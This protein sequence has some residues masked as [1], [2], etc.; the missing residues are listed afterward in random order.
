MVFVHCHRKMEVQCQWHAS[1][2][3][4]TYLPIG[5]FNGKLDFSEG[6]KEEEGVVE[7]ESKVRTTPDTT[8]D[9][10]TTG[11]VVSAQVGSN[12]VSTIGRKEEEQKL[13]N[14]KKESELPVPCHAI[15][16]GD[17]ASA[18][19]EQVVQEEGSEEESDFAGNENGVMVDINV[20]PANE[21]QQ[22]GPLKT[23]ADES[24][25]TVRS[26]SPKFD[27]PSKAKI[28][29]DDSPGLVP[30][31]RL[32]K[33]GPPLKPKGHVRHRTSDEINN[34]EYADGNDF[35]CK[36]SK[37]HSSIN[38]GEGKH[39]DDGTG[40]EEVASGFATSNST[41]V[42]HDS[43]SFSH[44]GG[45]EQPSVA[46]R[47][48]NVI[49]G[50]SDSENEEQQS[51]FAGRHSVISDDSDSDTAQSQQQRER[52]GKKLDIS[53]EGYSETPVVQP[54]HA[55][56]GKGK[57]RTAEQV[58]AEE[59]REARKS[60]ETND[61]TKWIQEKQSSLI[62]KDMDELKRLALSEQENLADRLR[63]QVEHTSRFRSQV[64]KEELANMKL[65][66][67][68]DDTLEGVTEKN[69]G[70]VN[71]TET[72][73]FLQSDEELNE[74]SSC[75]DESDDEH[76]AKPE[77]RDI[78]DTETG[79]TGE[80]C[81]DTDEED[82]EVNALV[83]IPPTTK[84]RLTLKKVH[85]CKVI[86]AHRDVTNKRN[87]PVLDTVPSAR[88]ARVQLIGHLRT[89]CISQANTRWARMLDSSY[90]DGKE[91]LREFKYAEM[92]RRE[93]SEKERQVRIAAER[94][95]AAHAREFR[96]LSNSS[97]EELE[98]D[99]ADPSSPKTSNTLS[100]ASGKAV[101]G[102]ME[103]EPTTS[104]S[105]KSIHSHEALNSGSSPSL[106]K[107]SP[108][109][110]S[111]LTT[112]TY[113]A[114]SQEVVQEIS[115]DDVLVMDSTAVKP[116]PT[117]IVVPSG[118]PPIKP[119][120]PQPSPASLDVKQRTYGRYRNRGQIG[121]A[122]GTQA[123]VEG[124]PSDSTTAVTKMNDEPAVEVSDVRQSGGAVGTL[125]NSA[126]T[127]EVSFIS[128]GSHGE[129]PR[130]NSLDHHHHSISHIP[131]D[132][133]KDEAPQEA[134]HY[135][136]GGMLE[137]PSF[138]DRVKAAIDGDKENKK[139]DNNASVESSKNNNGSVM[140]DVAAMGGTVVMHKER[141]AG[142]RAMLDSERRKQKKMAKIRK[143]SGNVI[144]EEAEE[145]EEE[146]AVKGLGDFGFGVM[147]GRNEEAGDGKEEENMDNDKATD[148]DLEGIV[149][150]YSDDEGDDEAAVSFRGRETAERDKAALR[151]VLRQVKEGFGEARLGGRSA[152]ARGALRTDQLTAAARN[153]RKEAKRLG[154][155]NSDEEWSENEQNDGRESEDD[156]DEHELAEM[157][158]REQLLRH[159][160]LSEMARDALNS[161]DES[162]AGDEDGENGKDV[163]MKDEMDIAEERMVKK[164]SQKAK[165]RRVLSELQDINNDE[166]KGSLLR[167]LDADSTSQDVLSALQ[168]TNSNMGINGQ[169]GIRSTNK[170][171]A[172]TYH[173][174][175]L[176]DGELQVGC[177][178][179]RSLQNIAFIEPCSS[180]GEDND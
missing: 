34:T 138:F 108:S 129:E 65:K 79:R 13:E 164:W 94:R 55:T 111:D 149:D 107:L 23:I 25:M 89:K 31:R 18:E 58:K 122:D 54:E 88:L 19:K 76:I 7:A 139:E 104:D 168:C 17:T 98:F 169:R 112:N 29:S 150:T 27:G 44:W 53:S 51:L 97:E 116:K 26:G 127:Q 132:E 131:E 6:T 134:L 52:F 15:S 16:H 75:N 69:G 136:R 110:T 159:M 162:D 24:M 113:A 105:C 124:G 117:E 11:F 80:C 57:G 165:I 74:N 118:V 160:G 178:N 171:Q 125:K 2:S 81:D 47:R 42:T 140:I 102:G 21:N 101:E 64:A 155:L 32:K 121:V 180:G 166:D 119:S 49:F 93:Q 83:I 133:D 135:D 96:E 153:S 172:S 77:N 61:L 43:S 56:N 12:D 28:H 126:E 3:T 91:M 179:L 40:T 38:L 36:N 85:D 5:S 84:Q 14:E 175:K 86:A 114:E 170:H 154:L 48:S 130:E 148:A 78:A 161:S 142:Y 72:T 174:G 1:S 144:D 151:S 87:K 33:A 62:F 71:E 137:T 99:D 146:T 60:V 143:H 141:N 8:Q 82:D 73:D 4:T 95:S 50:D 63:T 10:E 152:V 68:T 20:I 158:E 109:P 120:L 37:N 30:R 39:K 163:T 70:T 176:R 35:T 145:D 103:E 106:R 115:S 67:N 177:V 147:T 92:M 59:L 123:A 157:V 22:C 41:T 167:S 156:L 46:I 9:C 66:I 45:K 100:L 128:N 90:K 173:G